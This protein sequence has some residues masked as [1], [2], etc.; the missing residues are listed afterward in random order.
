M[1]FNHL[2]F[3]VDDLASWRDRFIEEWGATLLKKA[4][5]GSVLQTLETAQ[6]VNLGQVPIILS[7]PGRRGDPVDRYLDHHPPGI[8][9]VAFRVNGSLQ[10]WLNRLQ[11]HG[12]IVLN[13]IQ[14]APSRLQWCRVQ[15]W[16][17][18]SHT[19]I[20]PPG[21]GL[22]L[23]G[24]GN[25]TA[26][27]DLHGPP[28]IEAVDHAVINVPAGQ[29]ANAV[30]WYVQ[31]F[32]F[33]PRQQFTIDTPNSGLRSQVLAHPQ[34]TAQLPIN[35][36]VTPNSQVQ[37]FL[38]WNRGTGVQHV[39]LRTR[40]ILTTVQNLKARGIEFLHVPESY[41]RALMNRPGYNLAAARLEAIARLGILVDWNVNTPQAP[42]LQ[43]FTQPLLDIPTL[44]F[45][46]I[47]RQT[48]G[49]KNLT[50]YAEGFGEHNFQALFEAIE[51]EQGKRGS[52]KPV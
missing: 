26:Q 15:G 42:L 49:P 29:L 20:Q 17:K 43:T 33:C 1:Q 45:E 48:Q 7:A 16:A 52:L 9:D 46:I 34:G 5:S 40:N 38:D 18:L 51:R 3:F 31:R 22:W 39:A 36:P 25:I 28:A 4:S 11:A 2:H 50:L 47:Q 24:W 35:E 14:S 13:E 23:P 30:D 12:G 44:F 6:V 19:L 8:G 10:H 37:E 21:P 32:G 41:Y 27:L